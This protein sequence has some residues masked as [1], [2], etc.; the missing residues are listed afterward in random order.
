MIGDDPDGPGPAGTMPTR[1]ARGPDRAAT[2][3]LDQTLAS[4]G[5]IKDAPARRVDAL[6]EDLP[7]AGRKGARAAAVR[8]A[9]GWLGRDSGGASNAGDPARAAAW[10]TAGA[11]PTDAHRAGRPRRGDGMSGPKDPPEDRPEAPGDGDGMSGPKDPPEDRPEAPGD[12]DG[13]SG[14]KDPPEDRPEAPGDDDGMSGPKDPPED[15]P[16]APGD[17]DGMS[18]PK[19]P[20]EDRPEAPGD[21]DGMSGPKDPPEDRPEAPDDDDG[22]SGPK[23]PPE[24]RPEAPGDGDGMSGPKDPPEDRPEP[25]GDGDLNDLLNTGTSEEDIARV[26][27]RR[28]AAKPAKVIPFERP[29]A[30]APPDADTP[31]DAPPDTAD[32]GGLD[33]KRLRRGELP[34][35]CPVFP[36]GR[37]GDV[38]HFIDAAS[39]Y[40]PIHIDK[41]TP[42][43]VMDLFVGHADVLNHYWPRRD[44]DGHPHPFKWDYD[45]ALTSLTNACG[46]RPL[47]D[48]DDAVRGPGGWRGPD[49]ELILHTGDTLWIASASVPGK[50]GQQPPGPVGACIYPSSPALAGPAVATIDTLAAGRAL[51]ETF[52]SW[53]WARPALDP[54]LMLGWVGGAFLGGALAWR[55]MV[56]I[57]GDA[58]TGKSTIHNVTAALFTDRGILKSADASAAWIWQQLKFRSIP[59]ALDELEADAAPGKEKGIIQLARIASSGAS[60]GRGG[61]DHQAQNFNAKSGFIFDSIYVPPLRNQDLSRMA[62]LQLRPLEPG[63]PQPELDPAHWREIGRAIQRQLLTQWHRFQRTWNVY[64]AAMAAQGHGQR[65]IDQ[66]ATLVTC[67]DLLTRDGPPDAGEIA[68]D[69]EIPAILAALYPGKLVEVSE[70]NQDWENFLLTLLA[71]PI[72]LYRAGRRITV[73]ECIER[74]HLGPDAEVKAEAE[75]ALAAHGMRIVGDDGEVWFVIALKHAGMRELLRGEIWGGGDG[76]TTAVWTQV[77]ERIPG[78]KKSRTTVRFGGPSQRGTWIPFGLVRPDEDGGHPPPPAATPD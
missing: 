66:F 6:V 34:P 56:W 24:D 46:R 29:G 18:G 3:R 61:A 75:R 33:R 65:A 23:D 10:P 60:I 38:Y 15:R 70:R 45:E 43:R 12:G 59:V 74:A 1:I 76:A 51:F 22:M 78:M 69:E 49:G 42:K 30:P 28:A 31:P 48:P 44:K 39:Q 20:P 36:I 11:W 14:P 58:S 71:K 73:G 54:V 26:L 57:T 67:W 17:G 63:A 27:K 37:N 32:G 7:P 53:N 25:P 40:K 35:N 19:D 72:E 64:A 47:W 5:R 50:I 55:P 8:R 21:D 62:I 9:R 41:L 2:R 13:M 4:V 68:G 77:C 16:E 52:Q